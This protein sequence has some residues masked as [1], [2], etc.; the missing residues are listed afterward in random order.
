MPSSPK[1]TS[2]NPALSTG[3]SC[4]KKEKDGGQELGQK[5]VSR[6]AGAHELKAS[7]HES[8]CGRLGFPMLLL[9]HPQEIGSGL[10]RPDLPGAP[11]EVVVGRG[12]GFPEDLPEC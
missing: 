9:L 7:S 11:V 12:T 5:D 4:P 6:R 1:K 8:R 10:D 2:G 3:L